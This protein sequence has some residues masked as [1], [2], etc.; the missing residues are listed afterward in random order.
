MR[1]DDTYSAMLA[2]VQAFHHKHDFANQGAEDLIYRVALMAEE[3]GEFSSAVNKG[4]SKAMMA[5]ELADLFILTLGTAI[6]ADL[7]LKT[8]FWTKMDELMQRTS[9]MVDGRVRV[10][11]FRGMAQKGES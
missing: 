7:D 9:R 10:S 6:A 4:K 5:E 2:A 1:Q 11:R 3:L 8:A